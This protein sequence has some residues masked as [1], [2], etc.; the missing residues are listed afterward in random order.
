MFPIH[1]PNIIFFSAAAYLAELN[2]G[3]LYISAFFHGQKQQIPGCRSTDS[4]DAYS[5]TLQ[6]QYL[7][8]DTLCNI[9]SSNC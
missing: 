2:S 1:L 5:R 7:H 6:L 4:N 9:A 3:F 8:I